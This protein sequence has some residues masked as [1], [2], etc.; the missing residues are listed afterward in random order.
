MRYPNLFRPL[1]LGFVTLPNRIM[2]GSMHTMLEARPDGMERLAAF[3]RWYPWIDPEGLAYFRARLHQAPRDCEHARGVVTTHCLS[4]ESQARAI[5]AL[6]FKC[7]V[8]WA[9]LDAIEH[10]SR[11]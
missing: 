4:A 8:L 11:P 5:D 9:M 3:E 10:A 6:S 7:D 1:D 2:M